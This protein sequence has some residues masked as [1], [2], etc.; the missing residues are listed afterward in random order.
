MLGVVSRFGSRIRG[1][2]VFFVFCNYSQ[3]AAAADTPPER[4]PVREQIQWHRH[5]GQD[6]APFVTNVT[7][8]FAGGLRSRRGI[9]A[10]EI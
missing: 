2:L 9:E 5:K 3:W 8:L 4:Q 6:G 1:G 7:R 10:R